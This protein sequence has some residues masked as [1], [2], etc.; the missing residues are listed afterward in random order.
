MATTTLARGCPS[1]MGLLLSGCCRRRRCSAAPD[2]RRAST[3]ANQ[4][5]ARE[6]P[7]RP[8]A[9]HGRGGATRS[10]L[11]APMRAH[12]HTSR[13]R[14]AATRESRR[15]FQGP[16]S[17]PVRAPR[18]SRRVPCIWH[19]ANTP[20][21]GPRGSDPSRTEP[22]P[23]GDW[24]RRGAAEGVAPPWPVRS[25][26][27][28]WASRGARDGRIPLRQIR[29]RGASARRVFGASAGATGDLSTLAPHATPGREPNW[30]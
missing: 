23:P 5:R 14:R 1:L 21:G 19:A 25:F 18:G 8:P 22:A 16:A 3:S 12:H 15:P 2:S 20:T 29:G 26:N 30:L 13:T 24:A 4:R 17:S 9:R 11:T 28:T 7:S 6:A 10:A 27:C